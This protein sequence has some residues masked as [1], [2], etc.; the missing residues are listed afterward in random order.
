VILSLNAPPCEIRHLPISADC[1][2][3][4]IFEIAPA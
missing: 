3:K 4:E 1:N 2:E